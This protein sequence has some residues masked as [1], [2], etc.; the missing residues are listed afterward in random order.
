LQSHI[1]LSELIIQNELL[2]LEKRDIINRLF[3][4]RKRNVNLSQKGVRVHD[5]PARQNS[6]AHI[7]GNI[8]IVAFLL[9]T[10]QRRLGE[11]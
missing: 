10:K 6:G 8:R 5:V 11:Q 2:L 7:V 3:Q 4:W 1:S 9:Y